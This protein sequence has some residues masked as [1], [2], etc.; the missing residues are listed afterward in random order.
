MTHKQL[1]NVV[2][3]QLEILA[4]LAKTCQEMAVTV[5]TSK[6]TIL[7]QERR[8]EQLENEVYRLGSDQ[9]VYG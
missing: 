9:V 6:T 3:A 8:I 5:E 1:E 7:N 4:T 2:E